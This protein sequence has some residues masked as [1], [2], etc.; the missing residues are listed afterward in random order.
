MLITLK[1]RRSM[2]LILYD[3][4]LGI[5][6]TAQQILSVTHAA[7]SDSLWDPTLNSHPQYHLHLQVICTLSVT[8]TEAIE[9]HC[10][11]HQSQTL[12]VIHTAK[13][14]PWWHLHCRVW[15]SVPPTMQS[16]LLMSPTQYFQSLSIT[17]P[18]CQADSQNKRSKRFLPVSVAGKLLSNRFCVFTQW[19]LGSG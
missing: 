18:H 16:Q 2:S 8:H 19:L 13:S 17:H 4:T 3:Q 7:E 5:G 15:H 11:L 1:V 12:S 9:S 6:C 14:E 10:H